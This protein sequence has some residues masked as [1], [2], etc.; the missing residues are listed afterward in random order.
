MKKYVL[1]VFFFLGILFASLVSDGNVVRADTVATITT[2]AYDSK[3]ISIELDGLTTRTNRIMIYEVVTCNPGEDG[4]NTYNVGGE[5]NLKILE[6]ADRLGITVGDDLKAVLSYQI[7]TPGDGEKEFYI[8]P[9]AGENPLD[10]YAC[11]FTHTLSTLTQRIIVNPNGEGE[12]KHVFDHKQYSPVRKLSISL[13]LFEEEYETYSGVVYVC[14]VMGEELVHCGDYIID[15]EN[16]EYYLTSY[17]DGQKYLN[18]FLVK[19]GNSIGDNKNLL[20]ELKAEAVLVA[21]DIYLDTIGPEIVVEGGNWVFVDTGEKYVEQKATCKDAVFSEFDC[22][23]TNDFS[24]VGID[25]SNPKYQ[26]ITYEAEDI[27]GN[28]ATLPVK[29]KVNQEVKDDSL[30]VWLIVCGSIM[31]VTCTALGYILMKNHEKKKKLSYI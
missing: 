21:K 15:A 6:S 17:G 5:K 25:Y 4:C 26:I 14:E 7:A 3:K 16:V 24:V 2:D 1:G 12:P 8:L 31:L 18:I 10:S 30:G 13:N 22:V 19:A 11:Y 23:A 9:F 20:E 27:L 29:I 28:I